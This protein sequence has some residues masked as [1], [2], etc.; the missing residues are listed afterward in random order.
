MKRQ[1][2]K[3]VLTSNHRGT[4]VTET[5]FP[6]AH[7]E[8]AMGKDISPCGDCVLPEGPELLVCRNLGKRNPAKRDAVF[9][10]FLW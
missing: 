7:R 2:I 5:F 10:A 9:S 4:E 1:T 6:F 3:T 8:T